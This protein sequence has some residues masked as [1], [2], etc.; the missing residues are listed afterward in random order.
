MTAKQINYIA[1]LHLVYIEVV[2]ILPA[3]DPDWQNQS[4]V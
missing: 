1:Q 2:P 3:V 4:R